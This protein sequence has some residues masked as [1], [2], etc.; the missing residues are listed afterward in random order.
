VAV[1]STKR[2][3]A[4]GS[5]G[6]VVT[7][8]SI[9]LVCVS[10]PAAG[11]EWIVDASFARLGSGEDVDIQVHDPSVSRHHAVFRLTPQGWAV[12]DLNSKNGVLVDGVRVGTG[13]LRLD[14]RIQ[15]GTTLLL[16]TPRGRKLLATPSTGHEFEGVLGESPSMLEVFGILSKVARLPVSIVLNG[17][18]GAG[19]GALARAIHKASPRRDKPFVVLDCANLDANLIRAE[20]FGH[21]RGAFT[22][23]ET[24]R[25]GVFEA[26]SGG[27]LFIDEIGELPLDLQPHLLRALDDREVKR[28]GSQTSIAIDVRIVAATHR[29]L[30]QRVRDGRFREDLLYRLCVVELSVPPLCT[31]Q[32]DIRLLSEHW[33]QEWNVHHLIPLSAP[34]LDRLNSHSWPGN[35]RELRNVMERALAFSGGEPIELEHIRI[36]PPVHAPCET[37]GSLND[38]PGSTT[39]QSEKLPQIDESANDP[40]GLEDA[41]REVIL[42]TLERHDGNRTRTA[43]ELGIALTTLRRKLR[44]HALD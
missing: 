16:F 32:K 28:L 37:G 27:T 12:E 4:G 1:E 17:P 24:A 25:P 26:A 9:K 34:I 39:G 15:L 5:F 6:T 29:D 3:Q 11:T 43:R 10:G 18:T 2:I 40:Q 22:G 35:V 38:S 42:R 36:Q 41:E 8:P 31:R 13:Y 14:S 33:L 19:K 30:R 7:L 23:A 20:L 44:K 21:E